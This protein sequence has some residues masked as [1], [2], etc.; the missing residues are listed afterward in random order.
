[1][2]PKTGLLSLNSTDTS[3]SSDYDAATPPLVKKTPETKIP[4]SKIAHTIQSR[5][6]HGE[7]VQPLVSSISRENAI[8]NK[9]N[10]S[11]L[12]IIG[13]LVVLTIFISLYVYNK[14]S[15]KDRVVVANPETTKSV[16]S[17][18]PE[19]A[20]SATQANPSAPSQL[21]VESNSAQANA[22]IKARTFISEVS[23][24]NFEEI[25][26]PVTDATIEEIIDD[27]ASK[28]NL[29]L[30]Q[31]AKANEG[32]ITPLSRRL[33][34]RTSRTTSYKPAGKTGTSIASALFISGYNITHIDKA[35]AIDYLQQAM[36]ESTSPSLSNKIKALL[37]KTTLELN[38]AK[39]K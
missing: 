12:T 13:I 24:N 25:L 37:D 31:Q 15:V 39:G 11:K 23:P 19:P 18:S 17:S 14:A 29:D 3:S 28:N 34:K 4:D 16:P 7:G 38:R 36:K 5:E 6:H 21:P 33:I 10:I 1:M 30:E 35:K 27:P 26:V 2:P 32:Q 8:N 22:A 9:A 20:K